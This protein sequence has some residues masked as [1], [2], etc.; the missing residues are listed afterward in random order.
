M[1]L[2]LPKDH[3]WYTTLIICS[4]YESLMPHRGFSCALRLPPVQSS[5]TGV[6]THNHSHTGVEAMTTHE[7]HGMHSPQTPQQAQPP[8]Q[9]RGEHDGRQTQRCACSRQP[10]KSMCGEP[11]KLK[12]NLNIS[13]AINWCQ[14]LPI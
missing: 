6:P 9:G 3:L 4:I 12:H 8:H 1:F 7:D 11:T 14:P 10:G 5:S 13:Y 2:D